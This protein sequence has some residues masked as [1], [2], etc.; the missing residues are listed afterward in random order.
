MSPDDGDRPV[1]CDRGQRRAAAVEDDEIGP[2]PCG[3][4]RSFED[5]RHEDGACETTSTTPAAHRLD[6]GER[7]GLEMVRCGMAS[8]S[9]ECDE[10]IE[11]WWNADRLGLDRAPSPHGDDHD[12]PLGGEQ[13]RDMSRDRSLADTLAGSDHRDRGKLEGRERRRIEPEVCPHVGN[14]VGEDTTCER[15]PLDGPE[16]RL[17]R[18]IDRD[19]GPV[20]LECRGDVVGERHAVAIGAA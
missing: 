6:A 10:R 2:E 16:H 14:S 5:V 19:L 13:P 18:E 20:A 3:D 8:G 12:F 7:S 17:V 4:A 1:D 9:R 11:R 15:K